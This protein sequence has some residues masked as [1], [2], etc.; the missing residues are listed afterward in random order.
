LKVER[1][2]KEIREKQADLTVSVEDIK[3]RLDDSEFYTVKQWCS[4]KRWTIQHSV[5]VGWGKSCV[6]LSNAREVEIKEAPEDGRMVGRYHQS[7]LADV[8]LPVQR[9]HGQLPLVGGGDH[10]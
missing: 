1:E 8:C 2:V 9:L 10:E 7:I 3:D 5:R 4:K 6:K